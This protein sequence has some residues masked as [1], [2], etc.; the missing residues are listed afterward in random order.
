MSRLS[1]AFT[2]PARRPRTIIIVATVVIAALGLYGASMIVTSTQWFC[3]D[4]CHNVHA[5]NK[6][7]F[8]ASAHAEISCM[9]CHYP[10]N[11][12]PAKFA[13][14]RA[15]KLLDVYPTV[16]GD[17][18]MPLNEYSRIAL[19][20]DPGTCTQCHTPVRKVTAS[21]GMI[22]DHD[23]HSE[24]GITCTVC[25]NRTAH[26]LTTPLSLPNNRYPEDFMTMRACFRCHAVGA[27]SPAPEFKAPGNCTMCHKPT[28]DL[29]PASHDASWLPTVT[30]G[31]SAGPGTHAEAAK[32]DS[33]TI[34]E[35][36]AEWS[37][38]REEFISEQPRILMRLID[39]D[40]EEPIDLPP[41]AAVSECGMCHD[42]ATFC[43]PCHEQYSEAFGG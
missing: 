16:T 33:S 27:T 13:I 8:Y 19:K 32:E 37:H 22:I 21:P 3:N 38:V 34:A 7:Q 2:D 31:A 6:L 30:A 9:A 18:P 39:V 11:M 43:T 41:A 4:A 25:H 26:A 10:A 12:D 17:F 40:T 14:D 5:D 20:M 35:A 24:R 28:F 36:A 1:R 15:D 23:V 29:R 42:P